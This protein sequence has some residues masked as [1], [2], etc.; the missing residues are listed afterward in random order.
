MPKEI[1]IPAHAWMLFDAMAKDP[2]ILEM[3]AFRQH[4]RT[5]TYDHVIAVTKAACWIA[6]KRKYGADRIEVI[7]KAA[8]LHDFYLYDYHGMRTKLGGWHAWRHPEIALR[9]AER[10]FDIEPKVREAIRCHMFPGTLF[11]MPRHCEGWCVNIA[12][13]I[14]S[15]LEYMGR[16]AFNS[17][18]LVPV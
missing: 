11:H 18:V 10:S 3:K 12:D 17:A 8:L 2:R 7:V 5:S 14:C 1:R 9:N 13:K 16:P 4:R 15:V 6:A